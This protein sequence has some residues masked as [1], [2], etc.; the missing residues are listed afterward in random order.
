MV[1]TVISS[2]EA[3]AVV[4][5][6]YAE[7]SNISWKLNVSRT[8]C[9]GVFVDICSD[10]LNYNF[11]NKWNIKCWTYVIFSCVL[12]VSFE[13]CLALQLC[14]L[15]ERETLCVARIS[16]QGIFNTGCTDLSLIYF[17]SPDFGIF[18]ESLRFGA[19]DMYNFKEQMYL[20]KVV[21][22]Q[23]RRLRYNYLSGRIFYGRDC[24][25][26]TLYASGV[27]RDLFFVSSGMKS[28]LSS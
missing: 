21:M 15:E 10:S 27:V 13:Q 28:W 8:K 3:L 16:F 5:Y 7:Y 19:S 1:R 26:K 23:D 9:Q 22:R 18:E 12:D 20:N 6:R 11:E 25:K 2:G 4:F 24:D 17:T 14:G